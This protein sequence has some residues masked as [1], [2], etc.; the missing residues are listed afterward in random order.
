MAATGKKWPIAP[1]HIIFFSRSKAAT[2]DSLTAETTYLQ[3]DHADLLDTLNYRLGSAGDGDGSLRGVG[4]HVS[5][6]LYLST[7]WLASGKKNTSVSNKMSFWQSEYPT[8]WIFLAK[9]SRAAK[10]D[11]C[12]NGCCWFFY[13]FPSVPLEFPWSCSHLSQSGSHTGWQAPRC[14]GSRG[15]CWWLCCLSLSC[16]CP[17]QEW[18][19]MWVIFVC[20]VANGQSSVIQCNK[21]LPACQWS[22]RML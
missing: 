15:A 18:G 20:F 3:H 1:I 17:G 2:T 4:E 10:A 16:L 8:S 22:W 11:V 21:P 6:H 12:F 14:V 13:F 7:C 9:G 19:K 5:R